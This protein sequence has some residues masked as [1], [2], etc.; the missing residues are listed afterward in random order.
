MMKLLFVLCSMILPHAWGSHT[1]L[2][3]QEYQYLIQSIPERATS[4]SIG[5]ILDGNNT[6]FV[7]YPITGPKNYPSALEYAGKIG[8]LNNM[9]QF[10]CSGEYPSCFNSLSW[11]RT[12]IATDYGTFCF[13]RNRESVFIKDQAD[14]PQIRMRHLNDFSA[15]RDMSGVDLYA[16]EFTRWKK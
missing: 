14:K 7:V 16:I 11:E 5:K 13:V 4:A 1:S 10:R 12:A 2:T 8:T 3:E 9:K 6:L 15:R